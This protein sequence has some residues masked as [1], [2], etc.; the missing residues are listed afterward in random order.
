MEIVDEVFRR[1][2][3]RRVEQ[4]QHVGTQDLLDELGKPEGIEPVQ[5]RREYLAV[6]DELLKMDEAKLETRDYEMLEAHAKTELQKAKNSLKACRL[7]EDPG[8]KVGKR[9]VQAG[10]RRC[11]ADHIT[12]CQDVKWKDLTGKLGEYTGKFK[13]D[14]CLALRK[15][16]SL[17]SS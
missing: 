10:F 2:I 15:A 9:E 11:I 3:A 4:G 5:L 14:A 7:G 8:L 16:K 6:K 1:C 13:G 17:I 12:V